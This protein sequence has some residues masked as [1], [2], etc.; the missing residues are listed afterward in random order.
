MKESKKAIIIASIFLVIV[1]G[2]V[3][4]SN[5]KNQESDETIRV[6]WQTAWSVQGQLI[7]TLNNTDILKNNNTN[8]EFFGFNYGGPLNEAALAGKIDVSFVGDVPAVILLSKSNDWI[9]VGKFINQRVTIIVPK[10]SEIKTISDLEEKTIAV[11][12][13]S[14]PHLKMLKS[15]KEN[16]LETGKNT[17]LVNLDITE[18]I[19]V[20]NAGNSVDWGE[21]SAFGSW[22]P[23]IAMFEQNKKAR[24]LESFPA[25]GV[26]VMSKEFISKHPETAKQFLKSLKEAYYYYAQ[27][28]EQANEWYIKNTNIQIEQELLEVINSYEPNLKAKTRDEINLELNESEIKLLDDLADVALENKIIDKKPDFKEKIITGLIE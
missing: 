8:A 20:I 22:D 7:Q 26:I 23:T 27:N 19:A 16:G 9:I 21:I 17:E 15:L 1:I 4:I 18:Q 12:F 25:I 6:G 28:Q 24:I 13:G 11:P 2:A 5:I 3:F 14:A 10:D